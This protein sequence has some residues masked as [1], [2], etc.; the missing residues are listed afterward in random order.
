MPTENTHAYV[1]VDDMVITAT[2]RQDL[3]DALN[4]LTIWARDNELEI[5]LQKTAAMVFR[6]G[7][8]LSTKDTVS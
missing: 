3:Q 1:Y 5:N 7:G 8:R 2:S 4:N 6:K